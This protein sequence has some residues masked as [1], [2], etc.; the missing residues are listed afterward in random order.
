MNTAE[1]LQEQ[2]HERVSYQG[3]N[4]LLLG[5]AHVSQK[6]ADVV[7]SLIESGE[8]DTVAIELDEIRYQAMTDSN[9]YRNMDLISI[10]KNK[11]TGL[12]ATNLAMSAYQKRLADQLGVEPGAEMKQAIHSAK[13]K[14]LPLWK[15][16][17]SVGITMKRTWRSL[18]FLEKIN[19]LFGFGGFFDKE[20]ISEQEIEKLKSGDML[21]STFNDFSENSES[22]Y[23]SLIDER[24]QFMAARLK[25]AVEN[26]NNVAK[27]VLVIIGAGHLKGLTRYMQEDMN[28]N[29]TIN[30]LNTLPP[31]SLTLKMLPWLITLVILSGFAWG[32]ATNKELGF[33]LIKTWFIYNGVLSGLG[34]LL[35]AAHPITILSAMLAAPFTSLNPTI[36]AGMVA[37]LVETMLRKPKVQDFEALQADA[38]HLKGWWKNPVT[39]ILLIFIFTNLGSA[40]ATWVSGFKIFNQ[41]I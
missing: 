21:E 40:V 28:T 13:Q 1:T 10:I 5:T 41:L 39:R 14:E 19:L 35:A 24:D 27:N 23:K 6:S 29:D 34:A 17:R 18:G 20:E 26:G 3:V 33:D 30:K 32:F 9:R 31:K 16:D 38:M 12:I 11:Q 2:P 4:F 36:A 15:V 22:L 8:F 7:E 25:Q 37:S